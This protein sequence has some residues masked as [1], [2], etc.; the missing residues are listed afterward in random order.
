M[1]QEESRKPT[2][3]WKAVLAVFNPARSSCSPPPSGCTLPLPTLPF[4]RA[5]LKSFSQ[6]LHHSHGGASG[7][8][9]DHFSLIQLKR[10][11]RV[12]SLFSLWICIPHLLF[13]LLVVSSAVELIPACTGLKGE[14]SLD[15]L[16]VNISASMNPPCVRGGSG[17][18]VPVSLLGEDL[19]S[20]L[21]LSTMENFL[22]M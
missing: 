12:E 15:R 6:P 13:F 17:F 11:S 20:R 19:L 7:G 3:S 16:P 4:S 9:G 18:K 5:G 2:G 22:K 10:W 21:L 1:L 8:G 14:D